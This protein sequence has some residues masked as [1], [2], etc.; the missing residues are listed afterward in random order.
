MQLSMRMGSPDSWTSPGH[1]VVP[2]PLNVKPVNRANF[3]GGPLT[4]ITATPAPVITVRFV[5]APFRVIALVMVT[6]EPHVDAPAGTITVSPST[7]ELIADWT[8]VI[9]V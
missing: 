8:A 5:P 1:T 4:E 7:A 2:P 9:E 6:L 3:P